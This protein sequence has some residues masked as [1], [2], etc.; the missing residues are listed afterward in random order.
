MKY[1]PHIAGAVALITMAGAL[2]GAAIGD[3][4]I[5]ERDRYDTLPEA[6]MVTAGNAG[7]RTGERPPDHYPLKT[8]E[9]TIEVAEL[10]LHG[11][12][13][14]SSDGVWWEERGGDRVEL[15]GEYG[16]FYASAD[17]ERLAREEA[18]LAFTGGRAE[19]QVRLEE[20]QQAAPAA[21]TSQ[22]MT[23]AEAPMALA[24]PAAINEPQAPASP[25]E[26]STGNA[27]TIDVTAALAA[28]E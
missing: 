10:A 6:Q 11:R 26:P 9:G 8:P 18:L 12:M 23:R 19:Y 3:S 17:A 16:D 28:R 7:L 20:R 4:R 21:G 22:R 15:A 25:R 24:E 1:A 5:L 27:K 13:R 14:G 2:S